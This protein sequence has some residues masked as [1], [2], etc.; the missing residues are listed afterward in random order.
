MTAEPNKYPIHISQSGKSNTY[1]CGDKLEYTPAPVRL[2]DDNEWHNRRPLCP[3]CAS[4]HFA[5]HGEVVSWP[6]K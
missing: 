6:P 5:I 4:Q 1:L 3:K 2:M